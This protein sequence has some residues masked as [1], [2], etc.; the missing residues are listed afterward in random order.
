MFGVGGLVPPILNLDSRWECLASHYGR[1]TWYM[2]NVSLGGSPFPV[3]RFWRTEKYVVSAGNRTAIF[4]ILSS[5]YRAFFN[6]W[7]ENQLMSLFYSY[8]AGSL[9]VSG[10]QVHLQE[11][12]Y[13][14]SHNHWFS[15]CTALFACSVCCGLS[16]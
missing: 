11:S 6:V 10:P 2:S 14:C 7:N 9:H 3:W 1:F 13:S 15:V 12:S 8:I 4:R 5:L 16:W